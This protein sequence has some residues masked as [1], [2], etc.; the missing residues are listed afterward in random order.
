MVF[1]DVVFFSAIAPLLPDYVAELGLSKAEAGVLSASY[2]AGTLIFALPAGL[3]A[4]HR[5]LGPDAAGRRQR[6]LRLRG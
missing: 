6:R 3:P 1:F 2:A 4:A 5:D